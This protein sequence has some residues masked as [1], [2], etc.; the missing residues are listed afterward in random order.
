MTELK[1][2]PLAERHEELGARMVDFAGWLMP[3]QYNS[4]IDE[5]KTVRSAAGLFD[6]GHMGQVD[7]TGPDALSYLQAISTNDVT[8]LAPGD[9]QYSMMLYP[10]GGV[11]DDIIIYRRPT[12][13]GYF[14]VINAGNH[15]KDVAWMTKQAAERQDLDVTVED[16]SDTTGMIALQGPNSEAIIDKISARDLSDQDYFSC[17]EA[18]IALRSR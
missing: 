8:T 5:H 18:E 6:L 1:R 13:A 10:D 12:G 14:V 15:D 2:T 4:I 16:V 7:V 9:A 11:I 3:I 17:R